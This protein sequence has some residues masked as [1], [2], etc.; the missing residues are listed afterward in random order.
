MSVFETFENQEWTGEQGEEEVLGELL[1][2]EWETGELGETQ[3]MELA[4]ELLE[5]SNEEELEE[6]LGKLVSGAVR[7]I[8]KFAKS[9]IGKTLIGGLKGVARAALPVVGGALGSF[10]APGVGTAIGSQ[11]G[12]MASKMFELELESMNE[13]EAEFEVARR[14]V[15]LS[16]AAARTAARAPQGAPPRAVAQAA[17][18][19]AARR[20]APGL[21]RAARAN[22]GGTGGRRPSRSRASY[23][24]YGGRAAGYGGWGSLPY[25][26]D[27]PDEDEPGGDNGQYGASQRGDGRSYGAPQNG[28]RSG[29]WQRQGRK[30]VIYGA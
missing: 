16:T 6:F 3:E 22:R 1:N 23:G 28:R 25:G 30:I 21:A 26:G 17:I 15:R 8:G 24:G 29:R 7:G 11:L 27:Q 10:V 14:V 19:T 20:H 5:I 12:S 4:A 18:L 2:G 13:E 9:G